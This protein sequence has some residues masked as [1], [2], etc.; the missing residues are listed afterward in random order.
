VIERS[1]P[2]AYRMPGR[3]GGR[4]GERKR[5]LLILLRLGGMWGKK[6]SR[7][8]VRFGVYRLGNWICDLIG[9]GMGGMIRLCL[10]FLKCSSRE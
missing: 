4:E 7:D 8:P 6:V 5:K 1:V 9:D 3:A 2:Q 10:I